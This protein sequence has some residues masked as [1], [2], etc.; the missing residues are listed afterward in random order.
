[1][2]DAFTCTECGTEF[3]LPPPVLARYPGWVPKL[4]LRCKGARGGGP[5][6]KAGARRSRTAPA[7]DAVDHDTPLDEDP[8]LLRVLDRFQEGPDTGVFTDG[9]CSPNPGPGGWGVVWVEDG[10]IVDQRHGEAADSTNN[11]MELAALIEACRMVPAER[12]LTV[13]SDSQLVVKTVNEWAAGWE[14]KGW[15]RKSGP[16]A[17]LDLVQ[18]LWALVKQRPRLRFEWARAHSGW[19]WNEYADAL[20]TL[21]LRRRPRRS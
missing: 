4:C 5:E 17:N 12:E 3:V 13:Y 16:I 1:M 19:R 15:K 14:R 9:S 6:A 20:A 7:R 10:T 2:A 21:H 18:E 11:R 8:A